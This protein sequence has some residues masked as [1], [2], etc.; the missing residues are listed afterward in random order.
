MTRLSAS[1]NP[2][3]CLGTADPGF[4][5][6]AGGGGGGGGD[7]TGDLT[8]SMRVGSSEIGV[9]RS[10]IG[11]G[12]GRCVGASAGQNKPPPLVVIVISTQTPFTVSG[13]QVKGLRLRLRLRAKEMIITGLSYALPLAFSVLPCPGICRAGDGFR[14]ADPTP[15]EGAL[16]GSRASLGSG[17]LGDRP[18]DLRLRPSRIASLWFNS[19]R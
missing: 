18:S 1:E 13:S 15:A 4:P 19:G 16:L 6:V 9:R 11:V 17:T 10:E 2:L 3:R 7:V 14:R 12:G 8:G 5:P